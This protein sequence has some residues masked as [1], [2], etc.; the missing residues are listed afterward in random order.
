MSTSVSNPYIFNVT[1]DIVFSATCLTENTITITV[2]ESSQ[3]STNSEGTK[4][5]S[6]FY[7]YNSSIYNGPVFGKCSPS[8]YRGIKI[9]SIYVQTLVDETL[10]GP[11]VSASILFIQ[12]ADHVAINKIIIDDITCDIGDFHGDDNFGCNYALDI[13]YDF[14]ELQDHFTDNVGKQITITLELE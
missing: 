2:G 6:Y 7:G 1:K 14:P 9:S 8:T 13:Q 3:K 12:F 11:N 4:S 10:Q 5:T